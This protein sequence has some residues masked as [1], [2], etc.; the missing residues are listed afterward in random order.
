MKVFT[1][2]L[3]RRAQLLYQYI[4]IIT[5]TTFSDAVVWELIGE[6]FNVYSC[7]SFDETKY[8]KKYVNVDLKSLLHTLSKNT[9]K[10]LQ[11]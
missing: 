1:L 2:T 5:R 6:Y 7:F 11:I 8:N 3:K 10:L 9:K 4:N